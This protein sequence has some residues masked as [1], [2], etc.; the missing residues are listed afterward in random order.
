MSIKRN[1]GW[2]RVQLF[3][4]VVICAWSPYERP[5]HVQLDKLRRGRGTARGDSGKKA[6]GHHHE[7]AKPGRCT[8]ATA[9]HDVWYPLKDSLVSSDNDC[10][11]SSAL[12]D[13]RLRR[14]N[15][16]SASGTLAS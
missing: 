5:S 12:C 2:C 9:R 8:V 14:L 7:K 3:P 1:A 16:K 4:G 10:L 6:V 13:F 11:C 15:A